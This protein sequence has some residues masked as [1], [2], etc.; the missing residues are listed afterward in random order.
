MPH[1]CW[2]CIHFC[3]STIVYNKITEKGSDANGTKN[4]SCILSCYFAG[5]VEWLTY[6]EDKT[7]LQFSFF[8]ILFRGWDFIFSKI[9]VQSVTLLLS[10]KSAPSTSWCC[11]T[12]LSIW[13]MY[14]IDNNSNWRHN[15]AAMC[16]VLCMSLACGMQ[17]ICNNL[18][19]N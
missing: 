10:R 14:Q 3:S 5:S 13:E 11:L 9:N 8:F 6:K 15:T 16:V 17:L 18:S 4:F 19:K 1:Y 12:D 7:I 2:K